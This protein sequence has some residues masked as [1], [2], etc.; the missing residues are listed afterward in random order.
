MNPRVI[1]ELSVYLIKPLTFLFTSIL[2]TSVVSQEWKL[3]I[4]TPTLKARSDPHLAKSYRPICLTSVVSK[5]FE[6]V[7]DS[8]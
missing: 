3:G 8:K 2:E 6:S 4:I 5:L 7:D 1:K